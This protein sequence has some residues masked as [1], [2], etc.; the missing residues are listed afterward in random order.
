VCS[1]DLFGQSLLDPQVVP[2]AARDSAIG[3]LIAAS[4]RV[5]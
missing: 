3:A 5:A 1:S 4:P 2:V